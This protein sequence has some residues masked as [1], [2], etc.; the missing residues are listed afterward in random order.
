MEKKKELDN[1]I[2]LST[3][4]GVALLIISIIGY[5]LSTN[6]E[7]SIM[8]NMLLSISSGLGATILLYNAIK[9]DKRRL[10]R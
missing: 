6:P 4:A 1:G 9:N 2:F 10:A 3:L 7:R 8:P 5:V